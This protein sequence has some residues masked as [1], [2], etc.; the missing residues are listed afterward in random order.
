MARGS[1]QNTAIGPM[2]IAAVEQYE[3]AGRR[4]ED[5]PLAASMVAPAVRAVVSSCRV[6]AVRRAMIKRKRTVGA[7]R[8]G[9]PAVPEAL[10]R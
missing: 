3:P 7:R 5:D 2:V 4:I 9:I 6:P 8:L 10:R 1:V